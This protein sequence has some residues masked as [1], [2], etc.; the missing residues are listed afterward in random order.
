MV[1]ATGTGFLRIEP[2]WAGPRT[3]MPAGS[4]SPDGPGCLLDPDRPPDPVRTGS[5]A[6]LRPRCAG[7]PI[8]HGFAPNDDALPPR[9]EGWARALGAGSLWGSPAH[10]TDRVLTS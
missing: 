9:C 4:G 2:S 6:L 3:R 10:R 5:W 1:G 7:G 8:H